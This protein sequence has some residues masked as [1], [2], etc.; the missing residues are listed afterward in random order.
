MS[1]LLDGGA[2]RPGY[3]A[4][5]GPEASARQAP[6]RPLRPARRSGQARPRLGET[7]RP[8]TRAR[9]IAGRRAPAVVPCAPRQVPLRWPWLAALGVATALV[10]AGLGLLAGAVSPAQVPSRTV[11]VAVTPGETLSELAARFAPESD[12]DA[13]VAEIK[14]LNGL[15][16]AALVPG[17]P[18]AVPVGPGGAGARD[19]G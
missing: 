4:A 9:V 16:D 7:R 11:T 3:A 2:G 12:P 6:P 13:V 19:A 10:V 5:A 8:P 18:L 17:V 1:V 15:D 14:A